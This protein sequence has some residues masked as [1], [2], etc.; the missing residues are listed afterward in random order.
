MRNRMLFCMVAILIVTTLTA[1]AQV[2]GWG[3]L[4]SA[5]N[6]TNPIDGMLVLQDQYGKVLSPY[7]G[8]VEIPEGEEIRAQVFISGAENRDRYKVFW[9]TDTLENPNSLY[10]A[11]FDSQFGWNFLISPERLAQPNEMGRPLHLKIIDRK[12]KKDFIRVIFKIT[13]NMKSGASSNMLF[14]KSVKRV[15]ESVSAEP[16][17][18]IDPT[19][20]I[21]ALK[22]N[23]QKTADY[24]NELEGR[25]ST[26]ESW[27]AEASASANQMRQE[28][29]TI[30]FVGKTTPLIV[31]II[32]PTGKT[33]ITDVISGDETALSLPIGKYR[34]SLAMPEGKF[35]PAQ[36]FN[37][38]GG[39]DHIT[40]S[41]GGK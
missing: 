9:G 34:V 40:L 39:M 13:Y 2:S 24:V 3:I 25:V 21:E 22:A 20:A 19:V 28:T 12:G 23:S 29:F 6:E 11:D 27:A 31:K 5:G 10:E 36:T 16:I 15:Q 14:L 8:V 38:Y 18:V 37:V 41:L 1:T 32:F 7:N 35:G 4:L 17:K 26:L 30:R 33:I